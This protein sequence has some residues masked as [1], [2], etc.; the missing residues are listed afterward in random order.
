LDTLIGR[1][2]RSERAGEDGLLHGHALQLLLFAGPV[3][4]TLGE[5]DREQGLVGGFFRR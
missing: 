2:E 1:L 5:T 4:P 3:R